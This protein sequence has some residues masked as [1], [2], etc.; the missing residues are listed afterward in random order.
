VETIF[1]WPGISSL[2]MNA[3]GQRDYPVIQAVVLATATVVILVNLIGDMA[4]RT[5]DPRTTE[6]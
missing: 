6:S 2:L 3:V 4:V 1:G 5:L